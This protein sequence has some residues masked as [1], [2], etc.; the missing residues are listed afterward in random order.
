MKSKAI[1]AVVRVWH[2]RARGDAQLVSHVC[3]KALENLDRP[4][5]SSRGQVRLSQVIAFAFDQGYE[6]QLRRQTIVPVFPAAADFKR[7]LENMLQA[8]EA[9]LT[10]EGFPVRWVEELPADTFS[11]LTQLS[12]PERNMAVL[13]SEFPR[14]NFETFRSLTGE[15][16]FFKDTSLMCDPPPAVH[17]TCAVTCH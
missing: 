15:T 2:A 16:V 3:A 14:L 5:E 11:S 7:M 9:I 12:L 10:L 8:I 13:A 6:L 1:L 4:G 17:F